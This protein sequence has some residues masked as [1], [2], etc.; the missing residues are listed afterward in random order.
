VAIRTLLWEGLTIRSQRRVLVAL[1]VLALLLGLASVAIILTSRHMS[2]RGIW[3]ALSV[4]LGGSFVGTGLYAWWRRPENR[5]GA[6]MVWVGFLFF[7]SSWSFSNNG[8]IFTLGFF[9]DSLPI[10]GLI[11]LVLAFPNGRLASRY[12]RAVVALAYINASLVQLPGAL[13]YDSASDCAQCPANAFLVSANSGVTNTNVD[14]ARTV[15]IVVLVL[16]ARQ[17][18]VRARHARGGERRL[19]GPVL[20]ASV[21]T[22]VTFA[23]LYLSQMIGGSAAVTVRWFAFATFVTV[24]YAFLAGLIRGRLARSGAVADLVEA[25]GRADDRRASLRDSI[26]TALGDSSLA[27]AY[28]IPEQQ[29]YVDGD[30]KRVELPAAG[31]GLLATPIDRGGEPLAVV[32]HDET[33]AEEQELVRAVGGAAALTLE[34]ERLSA[35]LR[36]RIEELRASRTRIIRA[37]D[38]ERRRLERDLHDGA[39]QRLVA[40][41]LNLRLARDSGDLD[42][43]RALIDEAVQELTEA[44]GELRELARGIHPAVLT[45]RGLDAAVNALAGRAQLPVEVAEVPEERLSPPVESTVYFVV[46]EALTNVTRY[47]HASHADVAIGRQNGSIVVR[48]CDDGIGGADPKRGS[49]LRG[50]ADRVAAVDGRLIVTSEPGSGTTVEAEIPCG[51]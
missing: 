23:A 34:N 41:A 50:L 48:V 35:E 9:T 18:I 4:A 42:S 47:A 21:A 7:L 31:S 29:A 8:T 45:D 20:Y 27:V 15:A 26:A 49:G 51:P 30:G 33:L 24:P 10:A 19:Y 44:T 3:A 14:V 40:L 16:V 39:Q 22:L 36:A 46:A 37:G 5:S 11:H 1:A 32:I 12:D 17:V 13:S 6:L 38:E 2:Q 28:W 25:L 43:M